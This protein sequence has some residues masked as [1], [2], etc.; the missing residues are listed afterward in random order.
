MNRDITLRDL[1]H[2][3]AHCGRCYAFERLHE[4]PNP[5][6]RDGKGNRSSR[7]HGS[8]ERPSETIGL[9]SWCCVEDLRKRV[10]DLE[11]EKTNDDTD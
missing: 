9:C 10:L 8:Q 11:E 7:A 3:R 4:V 1:E 2:L 5:S 6:C